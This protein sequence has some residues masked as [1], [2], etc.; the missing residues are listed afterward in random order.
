[1]GRIYTK[2]GDAGETGRLDGTRVPKNDPAIDEC[3]SFLGAVRSH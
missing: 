3:N 1:M 2:T